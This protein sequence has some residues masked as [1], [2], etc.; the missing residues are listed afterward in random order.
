MMFCTLGS[1]V[2]PVNSQSSFK[3]SLKCP[4][5]SSVSVA[6]HKI[7]PTTPRTTCVPLAKDSKSGKCTYSTS[8]FLIVFPDPKTSATRDTIGS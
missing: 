1:D 4:V 2:I 7:T 6:N 5:L 8:L 3:F